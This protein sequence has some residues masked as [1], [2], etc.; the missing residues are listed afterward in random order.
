MIN[1][2]EFVIARE[3]KN[4][5]LSFLKIFK[6][7]PITKNMKR[8]DFIEILKNYD[9]GKYKKSKKMLNGHSGEVYVISTSKGNFILKMYHK[10]GIK[11]NPLSLE[12]T[13]YLHK[14][15]II[16][17]Y[18][19][20]NKSNDLI[21]SFNGK[22]TLIQSYVSGRSVKKLTDKQVIDLAKLVGK[23]NLYLKKLVNKKIKAENG[24]AKNLQIPL[25]PVKEIEVQNRK[26]HLLYK[27]AELNKNKLQKSLIHRDIRGD[28]TIIDKG[29]I[30]SIID[31]DITSYDY[32]AYDLGVLLHGFFLRPT[33]R[34]KQISL[35]LKEYQKYI[36]FNEEE[37]KATYYFMLQR[38]LEVVGLFQWKY[39]QTR[40]E[41]YIKRNYFLMK[42]YL[43]L[44]RFGLD[45]FVKLFKN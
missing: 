21:C 34:E 9:L 3:E 44:E 16:V 29:K 41:D 17:P 19:I 23:I 5:V 11:L 14:R 7:N 32:L 13:D 27:I 2:F 37:K 8:K 30:S 26:E 24:L 15:R 31:W 4:G 38:I 36:K 1:D 43:D 22:D 6:I 10:S 40:N 12:A 18:I 33:I 35:F 28:N 42:S 45:R 25:S 39:S 20:R